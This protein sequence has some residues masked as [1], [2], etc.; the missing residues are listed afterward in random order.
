MHAS[1]IALLGALALVT[2]CSSSSSGTPAAATPSDDAGASTGTVTFTQVYSDIISQDCVSCH[3]P[4]GDG[5]TAGKLDMSSQ[6]TAFSNLVGVAAAGEACGGKGTRV[7]AGDADNSI[8]YQKVT[9]P[10]C[11]SQ[12]PLG[13]TALSNDKTEEIET[14]IKA[15]AMND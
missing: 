10:T 14:W 9:S 13:G 2:A 15:G 12:M 6:A 7:V 4:A 5:V 1:K 3:N 11:G 8:L